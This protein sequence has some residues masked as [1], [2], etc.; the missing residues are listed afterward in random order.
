MHP[1]VG[2]FASDTHL[3]AM[4]EITLHDA[5]ALGSLVR[6]AGAGDEVALARLIADHHDPMVKV[7]YV[8]L[9]DAELAR[10]AAQ[11]AWSVAWRRMRDLRDPERIRPWLVAIAANEARQLGRRERRR[12]VVELAAGSSDPLAADPSDAIAVV[13]LRTVLRQLTPDD[14]SLLA[15]RFV[16]GL[17]STQI[18]ERSGMSPSGVRSR[19]ARLLERLRKDLDDA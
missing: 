14:Q 1:G 16:G 11:A 4:T 2:H 10:E 8:I 12:T 13:D 18:G 6:R 5:T 19:M 7:A 17:D 15:M 3:L 9:G